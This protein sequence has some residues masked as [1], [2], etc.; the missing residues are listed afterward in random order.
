MQPSRHRLLALGAAAAQGIV[1]SQ[2]MPNPARGNLALTREHARLLEQMFDEPP[3]HLTL[4]GC[5]AARVLAEAMAGTRDPGVPALLA[6][7]RNGRMREI[8]GLA[9]DLQRSAGRFVD[10][11][12]IAAG[13]RLA[14]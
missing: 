4:E 5:F 6:A 12:V 7:L 9:V 1:L 11:A 14:G 2:V 13:G 10:L 8:G 3:S